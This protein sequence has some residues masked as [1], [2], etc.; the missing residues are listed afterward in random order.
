[1]LKKCISLFLLLALTLSLS[2]AEATGLPV[3]STTR[4]VDGMAGVH[5]ASRI[6]AAGETP[7][8]FALVTGE[9]AADIF[10]KGM[11]LSETGILSGAP[12]DAGQYHFTVRVTNPSGSTFI[13][14][15]LNIEA[16]DPL[17][18]QAGGEDISVIGE[19]NDSL[20][21]ISNALNGGQMTMQSDILYFIDR[22]GYLYHLSSPFDKKADKLFKARRYAHIDSLSDTLYYFHS[23]LDEGASKKS[24]IPSYIHRIARDPIGGKGRSTLVSLDKDACRSLSVTAELLLFIG[25]DELM[26]RSALDGERNRSIDLRVY[27]DGREIKAEDVF[28]YNGRMYIRENKTG[29]L[30]VAWLDG[31]LADPLVT[32]SVK[33]YTLAPI[34]EEIKLIWTNREDRLYCLSLEGG[35]SEELDKLK[36]TALNAND[37]CLF[38]ADAANKNRL[39]MID[40]DNPDEAIQLTDF[41]VDRI[42]SFDDYVA[43][44]KKGKQ[45]Y[46]ILPL[47]QPLQKPMRI[48]F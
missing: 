7:L 39:S 32:E 17:K 10:P 48:R 36:A 37:T 33:H 46:Y 41:A 31:Q 44:Q 27:H 28:P 3:V 19:G 22:Q 43:V 45:E 12:R 35:V 14:Y 18:L 29:H 40:R 34:G 42:Y 6:S 21:G 20:A 8:V 11:R 26:K 24:G 1:M 23:Y 5:Y 38:F 15:R 16:F 47:K 9:G 13:N 4:L 25:H 2:A 30:Y